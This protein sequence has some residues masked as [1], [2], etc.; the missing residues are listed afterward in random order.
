MYCSFSGVPG[1]RREASY[2]EV[3]CEREPK[4][5]KYLSLHMMIKINNTIPEGL[6]SSNKCSQHWRTQNQ[7]C[8]F[9]PPTNPSALY[10]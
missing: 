6:N 9:C 8:N 2:K 4:Q 5:F 3:G 7:L 1:P 10:Q